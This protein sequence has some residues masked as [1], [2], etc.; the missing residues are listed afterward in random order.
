MER[1]VVRKHIVT[2]AIL[3]YVFLY[4]IILCIKPHFLFNKDGSLREFGVGYKK[5]TIIPAWLLSIL[6]GIIS[7]YIVLYGLTTTHLFF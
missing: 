6:L 5:R 4:G 7:Y 2:T 1:A 3:I